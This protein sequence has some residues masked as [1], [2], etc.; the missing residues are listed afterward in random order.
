MNL[1]TGNNCDNTSFNANLK[2][3]KRGSFKEPSK[4]FEESMK[5]LESEWR[6]KAGFVGTSRDT[7]TI[8]LGKND[9]NPKSLTKKQNLS[10]SAKINGFNI[11]RNKI[12]FEDMKF[13]D[14]TLSRYYD[15][16][17]IMVDNFIEFCRQFSNCKIT[18]K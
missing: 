9:I 5:Y 1:N 12:K 4:Y 10:V 14:G 3:V 17:N 15:T 18:Q 8:T 11:K 2:I 13:K 16:L 7:I 6:N